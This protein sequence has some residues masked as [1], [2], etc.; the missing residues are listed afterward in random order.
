M[1]TLPRVQ[2]RTHEHKG[3]AALRLDHFQ[4]LVP[5]VAAAAKFYADL[6]FRVSDYYTAGAGRIIGAFMFRKNNPHD[7]VFFERAGPRF[8]HA[9]YIAPSVP[10]VIRGLE[11]AG[12]LGFADHIEHGPGHHG[13]GHSFYVYLR[14]PDGHRVELTLNAVQMINHDE[15][16]PDDATAGANTRGGRP[17]PAPLGGGGGGFLHGGGGRAP[18]SEEAGGGGG[19]SWRKT[20]R[21]GSP[22]QGKKGPRPVTTRSLCVTPRYFSSTAASVAS[23]ALVA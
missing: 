17:P 15:A 8:H 4:V 7:L 10:G 18:R 22:G 13:Q 2:T 23:V 11:A 12:Q 20:K 9:A 14:D 1:K 3:A 16:E 6:G 21:G 5:D 19:R